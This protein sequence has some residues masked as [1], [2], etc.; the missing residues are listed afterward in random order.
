MTPSKLPR[1]IG[2]LLTALLLTTLGC[3]IQI[4]L[5]PTPGAE[6][7][8]LPPPVPSSTLPV[9]STTEPLMLPTL[10]PA[11]ATRTPLPN[12]LSQLPVTYP[13]MTSEMAAYFNRT[14]R[15][16]D[17]A[18]IPAA[19]LRFLPAIESGRVRVGFASWEE[20]ER[21]LPELADQIDI[22]AY[23]PEHWAQTPAAE[24]A[25]L[26]ATVRRAADV[27]RSYGLTFMVSPDRRFAA[28][29]LA[30]IAPYADMIGLQGQRLQHD[31]QGFASWARELIAIA[32]AAN[33]NVQ[34]FVQVGATQGTSAQMLAAIET[35][36]GQIDGISIWTNARTF[37]ILE[38]FI[39]S[40]QT[41]GS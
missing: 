17:I 38:Q 27:A 37:P 33:P 31:P 21:R 19:Q 5:G 34:I 32:R 18:L 26:P 16:L 7:P 4:D 13:I 25:D 39:V 24:R 10:D 1:P 6:S 9:D 20:A 3:A 8:T 14:A 29:H 22:I 40:L 35:I 23:N 36:A 2:A 30:D 28:D 12:D 41:P 15:P 11:A